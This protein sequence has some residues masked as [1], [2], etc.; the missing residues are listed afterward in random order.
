VDPWGRVIGEAGQEQGITLATVDPEF[1]AAVRRQI[2]V[3]SHD[4]KAGLAP[5]LGS[6]VRKTDDPI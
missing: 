4:R 5:V 6:G 2:P 1:A 3:L